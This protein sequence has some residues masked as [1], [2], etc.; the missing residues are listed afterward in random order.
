MADDSYFWAFFHLI[1]CSTILELDHHLVL[2]SQ[3]P[4]TL[5]ESTVVFTLL[6]QLYSFQ[7][8]PSV[9]ILTTPATIPIAAVSV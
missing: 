2:S 1:H 4:V 5:L 7:A 9:Y 8:G 3:K 6:S